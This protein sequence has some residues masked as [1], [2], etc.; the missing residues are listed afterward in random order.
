MLMKHI[1][2]I[3]D[4]TRNDQEQIK[5]IS[6]ELLHKSHDYTEKVGSSNFPEKNSRK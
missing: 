1:G 5:H 3:F 2:E 6:V 4:V